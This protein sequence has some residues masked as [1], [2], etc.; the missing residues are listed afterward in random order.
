MPYSDAE[1]H[2]QDDRRQSEAGEVLDHEPVAD[3]VVLG[4]LVSARLVGVV[5]GVV[6]RLP[7]R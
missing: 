6:P 3:V 1:D 4:A 5:I 7:L 2:D